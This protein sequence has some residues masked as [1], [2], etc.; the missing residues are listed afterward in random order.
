MGSAAA[1]RCDDPVTV[2]GSHGPFTLRCRLRGAKN[3]INKCN[4]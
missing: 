3:S 1:V 4:F 2:C